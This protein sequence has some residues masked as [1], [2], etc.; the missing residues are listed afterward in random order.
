MRLLLWIFQN[1]KIALLLVQNPHLILLYLIQKIGLIWIGAGALIVLVFLWFILANYASKSNVVREA[2]LVLNLKIKQTFMR[3]SSFDK[4]RRILQ[5]HER[6][7]F[8]V[9]IQNYPSLRE[10]F[11]MKIEIVKIINFPK[12]IFTLRSKNTH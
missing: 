12:I 4:K 9:S 8:V 6:H 1:Q 11:S 10:K 2:K 3:K 5:T 7:K